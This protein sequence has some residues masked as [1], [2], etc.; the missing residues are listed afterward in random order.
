MYSS[1]VSLVPTPLPNSNCYKTLEPE[2]GLGYEATLCS[3]TIT[4]RMEVILL[5]LT[6]K[7][8]YIQQNVRLQSLQK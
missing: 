8:L 5:S 4:Q 2:E 7:Y 1:C 6:E 3:V